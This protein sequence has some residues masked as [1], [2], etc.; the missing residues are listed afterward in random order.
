ML[1]LYNTSYGTQSLWYRVGSY[2]SS[3]AWDAEG[4]EVQMSDKLVH[5]YR[6]KEVWHTVAADYYYGAGTGDQT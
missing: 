4:K 3:Y 1:I 6:L 2:P 5:V